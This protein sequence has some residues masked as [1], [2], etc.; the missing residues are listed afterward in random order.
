MAVQ[1]QMAAHKLLVL[2]HVAEDC[3][4]KHNLAPTLPISALTGIERVHDVYIVATRDFQSLTSAKNFYS[5][6]REFLCLFHFFVGCLFSIEFRSRE[7]LYAAQGGPGL[8]FLLRTVRVEV[9]IAWHLQFFVFTFAEVL[10]ACTT[11]FATF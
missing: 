1:H 5:F 8:Q 10:T 11:V 4:L 9:Y 6:E 2:L 7:S 3:V